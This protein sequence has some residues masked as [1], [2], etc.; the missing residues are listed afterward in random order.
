MPTDAPP[1]WFGPQQVKDALV[2]HGVP[3][4]HQLRVHEPHKAKQD[5]FWLQAFFS[6]DIGNER[7]GKGVLRLME[8]EGELRAFTFCTI[9]TEIVGHEELA[10]E[11][12]PLGVAQEG[13]AVWHERRAQMHELETDPVVLIIGAGHVRSRRE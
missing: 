6:F 8:H 9:S 1:A 7:R 11:R 12:R 2:K 13:E 4:I 5:A 10:Y 3:P